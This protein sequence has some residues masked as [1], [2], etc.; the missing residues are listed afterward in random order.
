MKKANVPVLKDLVL[1]GGGHSHIA[2][3]KRF[4]M[5]PIP[6]VRLTLICRDTHAPYSG[7]LPGLIAG[8]YGFDDAHID[9]GPLTRFAGAQFF[10]DEAIGLDTANKRVLCRDRPPVAYDLLSINI[11]SIPNTNQ[12]PGAA[13][14]A[15][16]V[17]PIDRFVAHW[18]EVAQR[19]LGHEGTVRIGVVGAGA[20]GVELLLSVQHRL[21]RMLAQAGRTG[22]DPEYHLITET[23]EILPTH[24]RRVRRKFTRILAERGINV[25]TG[26]RV[27]RV[28]AGRLHC[29]DGT[30]IALDEILWVTMAGAAPWLAETGLALAHPGF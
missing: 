25:H 24:N 3:L 1:L 20:G 2:V 14:H 15:V 27:S 21:G 10:H 7:M 4:G 17:K 28:D 6:G 18:H 11:G 13:E 29:Q 5:R 23:E 19:V 30:D 26:H 16:A 8:H 12:V 9:L 22:A